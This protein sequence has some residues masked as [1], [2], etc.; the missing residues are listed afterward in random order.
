MKAFPVDIFGVKQVGVEK[1][2]EAFFWPVSDREYFSFTD[3]IG[4]IF[5][6]EMQK[7]SRTLRDV[8]LSHIGLIQQYGM[9]L[10]ALLVVERLKETG[11]DVFLHDESQ[12]YPEI[13]TRNFNRQPGL[14][15]VGSAE[16]AKNRIKQILKFLLKN[17]FSSASVLKAFR[18]HKIGV[19]LGSFVRLK[20]EYC[21]KNDLLVTHKSYLDFLEWAAPKGRPRAGEI[22]DVIQNIV[23]NIERLARNLGFTL[24]SALKAY[25]GNLGKWPLY[26]SLSLYEGIVRDYPQKID[27]LLLSEVAKPINKTICFA[28]KRKFNTRVVGFEHG[29]TFGSLLSRYFAPSELAH[30]DEYIV[31][32]SK[33][34]PNFREAQ[35]TA[36]LP[37]GTETQISSMDTDYYRVLGERSK[38]LKVSEKIRRV[39]LIGFPMN[40]NRYMDFPGHFSL[41]HLDLEIRLLVFIKQRGFKAIYK[42]HPDRLREVKG[43][44]ERFSDEIKAEAF[45]EVYDTCDA[46]LFAHTET[47]TFGIAV[48]T[49]KPII[50]IEI[51]GKPWKGNAYELVSKRCRMVPARITNKCRILFDEQAL[52]RALNGRI[53]EPNMEY[54]ENMMV[55]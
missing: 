1:W 48:C 13:L 6:E 33:S 43:V 50:V 34:I 2:Q 32:A 5:H 40:Q 35:R 31:A 24:D 29:N 12:Y 54:L 28:L 17:R 30:C 51:E 21:N 44:F 25:L 3:Q 10:H 38:T 9:V 7:G 15:E 14:L 27:L 49:N 19:S 8:L 41:F 53:A 45:E 11:H 46:Y 26:L 36:R 37:Y 55:P 39:M 20:R 23:G 18:D 42:A 4:D 22:E 47:S 52:E 16:R